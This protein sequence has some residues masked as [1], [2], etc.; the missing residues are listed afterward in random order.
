MLETNPVPCPAAHGLEPAAARRPGLPAAVFRGVATSL[1]PCLLACAVL[2]IALGGWAWLWTGLTQGLYAA[3]ILGTSIPAGLL[4]ARHADRAL[5]AIGAA[6]PTRVDPTDGAAGPWLAFTGVE[7]AVR[8]AGLA[9]LIGVL[10]LL[11]SPSQLPLT[12]IGLYGATLWIG[13]LRLRLR[14]EDM[15]LRIRPAYRPERLVP[16]SELRVLEIAP[17]VGPHDVPP[18]VQLYTADGSLNVVLHPGF[19]GL[20]PLRAQ[21]R[22]RL[23]AANCTLELPAVP[24]LPRSTGRRDAAQEVDPSL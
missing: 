22:A 12:A 14:V 11:P 20:E 2:A 6:G 1:A 4:L 17:A 3:V 10:A 8:A 9:L 24:A 13:H 5:A 23:P 18:R 15:G 19:R 16:W 21:L 7:L